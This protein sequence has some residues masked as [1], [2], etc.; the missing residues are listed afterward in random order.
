MIRKSSKFKYELLQV[1]KNIRNL[2]NNGY[3]LELRSEKRSKLK[4]E[5][6]KTVFFFFIST[7]LYGPI[8]LVSGKRYNVISLVS[9]K[10]YN[11]ISMYRR[12]LYGS[13]PKTDHTPS[14]MGGVISFWGGT[15]LPLWWVKLPR[16]PTAIDCNN[17][18]V[19]DNGKADCIVV[20]EKGLLVSIEQITGTVQW[21][22]NATTH[23][24]LPV[25][26]PDLNNDGANELLSVDLSGGI[27]GLALISGKNGD[28]IAQR[29]QKDCKNVA[30]HGVD[31][32][33]TVSFSCED[34]RLKTMSLN[35]LFDSKETKHPM[36]P[37]FVPEDN[38]DDVKFAI[39]PLHQLS[40]QR[41]TPCPGDACETTMR[42]EFQNESRPIWTSSGPNSFGMKPAILRGDSRSAAAGFVMKFWQWNWPEEAVNSS[43]VRRTIT[44]RIL[45]VIINQTDVRAVNAS[46]TEISQVCKSK[47]L[48]CQPSLELQ[49][50]SLL[51]EDLN[52]DGRRELI[53]YHTSYDL[54]G[55]I[56]TLETKIQAIRIDLEVAKL[57]TRK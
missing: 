33:A 29:K 35:E 22:S 28:L 4:K 30:I 8:S 43:L 18:N 7:E 40:I 13:D 34:K 46:Q 53:S 17:H 56:K 39:S 25:F 11:V 48:E 10:R 50:E 41:T 9:G 6:F 27:P 31:A 2:K 51:V 15:E 23:S 52:N 38:D 20:G 36:T 5:L 42:V 24:K 3:K 54:E 12:Q 32:D 14:E 16:L 49:S 19:D 1:R 55:P 45:V 57:T 44:E 26:L 47:W 21:S 37:I